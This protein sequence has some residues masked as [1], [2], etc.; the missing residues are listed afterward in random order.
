MLLLPL[1]SSFQR[2]SETH[3]R[4]LSELTEVR[5]DNRSLKILAY[6]K[7]RLRHT[8]KDNLL[9]NPKYAW[10]AKVWKE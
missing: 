6:F 9:L 8:F 10:T 1:Q 5:S 2:Y 7:I 3:E 4:L